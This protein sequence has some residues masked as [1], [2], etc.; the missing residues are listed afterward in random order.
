[1]EIKTTYRQGIQEVIVDKPDYK[2][3]HYHDYSVVTT[4]IDMNEEYAKHMI[5]DIHAQATKK[6]ELQQPTQPP[7]QKRLILFM[8]QHHPTKITKIMKDAGLP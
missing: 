8:I 1:M 5:I 2:Q 6:Q 7:H 3:S 4:D